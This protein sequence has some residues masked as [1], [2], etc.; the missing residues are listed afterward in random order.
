M[1]TQSDEAYRRVREELT[2]RV[3]GKRGDSDTQALVEGLRRSNLRGVVK[4]LGGH[5]PAWRDALL[6]RLSALPDWRISPEL[7]DAIEVRFYT[8]YGKGPYSAATLA[9]VTPDHLQAARED[10]AAL[11]EI[12]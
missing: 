1:A 2:A 5:D 12:A 10:V 11:I 4:L 7:V 3:A 6:A 8:A 9:N